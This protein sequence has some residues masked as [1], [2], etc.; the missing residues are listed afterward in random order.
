MTRWRAAAGLLLLLLAGVPLLVPLLE[1]VRQGVAAWDSADLA[2]LVHLYRQTLLLVGGVLFLALPAG[3][4][5]AVLAFR[6]SWPGRRLFVVV[7][8]LMLFVPLSVQVSAWQGL[9]GSDGL[10]APLWW[11]A[12]P[13]RPWTSGLPPAIWVHALAALP[14]VIFLVGLSMTW[15]ERELEEEGLLCGPPA[16]VVW[17]LTLPRCKSAILLAAVWVALQTAGEIAVTD[18][19]QVSTVAE[20]V[21]TQFTLGEDAAL[22]R[23]VTGALPLLCLAWLALCWLGPRVEAVLPPLTSSW[24]EPRLLPFG[25][26]F[27]MIGAV[28]AAGAALLLAAPLGSLLWKLG[29]TGHP[30]T[31]V[32]SNAW[33]FFA[34]EVRV[35]GWHTV[36]NV[37]LAGAV[38]TGVSVAAWLLCWLAVDSPGFRRLVFAVAALSWTLPGPIIG[39]GL[40]ATIQQLVEWLPGG[41]LDQALYRGPSPLPLAWAWT[42]RSLPYALALLWPVVRLVPRESIEATRLEGPSRLREF[43]V[44]IVPVT[45]RAVVVCAIAMTALALAEVAASTRVDTPGWESYATLLFNRMHYGVDNSVA[46]LAL[47]LLAVVGLAALIVVSL[48]RRR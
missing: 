45:R 28:V 29:Q 15:V 13:G 12:S 34:N 48:R 5:L 25:P 2:R 18:M 33:Q 11:G 35:S 31:W 17:R 3:V 40:K 43:W 47:L 23:S 44:A 10:F 32:A 7:C 27:R 6:A 14:W 16:W 36:S 39:I 21:H 22:A 38:G 9:L 8:G 20:E 42:I 1:W 24:L 37:L 4:Y 19:L 41:A 30:P 26:W 46:A